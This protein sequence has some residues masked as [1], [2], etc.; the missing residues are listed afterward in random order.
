M[1]LI[2][3]LHWLPC[4]WDVQTAEYKNRNKKM[5]HMILWLKTEV[6]DREEITGVENAVPQ[7]TQRIGGFPEKR[8]FP[9]QGFW[10]GYVKLLFL[11][12][13]QG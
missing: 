6:G 13:F 1:T 8:E 9:K 5:M 2:E 3:N 10:F 11:F 7:E 12:Q 4:W